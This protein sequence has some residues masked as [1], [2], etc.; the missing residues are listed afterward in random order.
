MYIRFGR[1]SGRF[2]AMDSNEAEKIYVSGK[3]HVIKALLQRDAAIVEHK[4]RLNRIVQEVSRWKR[5]FCY[6]CFEK[7]EKIDKLEQ[8]VQQL[9]AKM[10]YRG[11]KEKEGY[12]GSSTPSSQR[13]FKENSSQE[14]QNKMGGAQKGHK[15]N[16]RRAVD[17]DEADRIEDI[18]PGE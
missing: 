3:E 18:F 6:S 11:K 12:F 2:C 16:G 9:K 17:E 8:E 1:I 5:G 4:Q 15:G 10:K 13:P 7:Q 14:N